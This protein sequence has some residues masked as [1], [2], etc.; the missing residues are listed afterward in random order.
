MGKKNRKILD[1]GL[2]IL[3][4]SMYSLCMCSFVFWQGSYEGLG[5]AKVRELG[6]DSKLCGIPAYG[7]LQPQSILHDGDDTFLGDI[8]HCFNN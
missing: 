5:L 4:K 7:R 6:R 3:N 8:I 2:T 1:I